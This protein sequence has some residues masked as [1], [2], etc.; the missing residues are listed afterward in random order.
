MYRLIRLGGGPVPLQPIGTR[1]RDVLVQVL[2]HRKV[3][4]Q[5]LAGI[6][7]LLIFW[8]FLILSTT[9][10]Q[11]IGEAFRP[12]WMLPLIGAS[13]VLIGLQEL[14]IALVLTG[15]AMALWWRLVRRP[16]RLAGQDQ[17]SAYLILMFIAGIMITLLLSRAGQIALERPAWAEGAPLSSLVAGWLE[18]APHAVARGVFEV[19]WWGHLLI[20]LLFLSL[21]PQGKHL[22]LITLA[23]NVFLRKRRPR[24]A[25]AAID[26]EQADHLGASRVEHF[27]WKDHLDAFACMECGRCVEACPANSTGKELDPRRLHTDLRRQ[28]A[29]ES[30]PAGTAAAPLLVG[31]VFSEDFLWQCLTCGACV[32]ECPAMNDHIDKIVEM[33]RH[34]TMEEARVPGTMGEA[35]RSLEARGHPFRGAGFSRTAWTSGATVRVLDGGTS[36]DWLLWT[37]CASALNERNHAPL[38]AL[39]RLL[40]GAGI[41]VAILGDAETCTG[42]PAR[43]IGN[44]YLFQTLAQQN[45]ETLNRFGIGKIV[46]P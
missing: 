40:G 38:R 31:G 28:L 14:F 20:I 15:V 42:D 36:P 10:V 17:R 33:R 7:H 5:P 8:G 16:P 3:L 27:T 24:G 44:E 37:G 23:P 21:I 26:I 30:L 12:G 34:L 29:V 6:L 25:L 43:R 2:G 19:A 9:I 39:A 1:I 45:I 11:A 46:T 13:L 22:H 32:E 35:L 4:R 18:R 41:D